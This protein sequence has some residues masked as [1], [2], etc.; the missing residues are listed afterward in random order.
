MAQYVVLENFGKY[1]RQQLISQGE[2][3]KLSDDEKKKV[4][5]TMGPLADPKYVATK[6]FLS[7]GGVNYTFG[8]LTT[9]VQYDAL[10]DDEKG[11]FLEEPKQ[12]ETEK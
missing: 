12:E 6:P 3:E 7:K 4:Q 9:K 8:Q 2:Y 10:E 5:N 1:S 11:N